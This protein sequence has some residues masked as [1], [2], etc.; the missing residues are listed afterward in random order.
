MEFLSFALKFLGIIFIIAM[1]YGLV[2]GT[3]KKDIEDYKKKIIDEYKES[4][5]FK[6]LTSKKEIIKEKIQN[7][8]NVEFFS[9]SGYTQEEIITF[10]KNKIDSNF[11]KPKKDADDTNMFYNKKVVITGNFD[12]FK[13]RNDLAKIL[14]DSGADIDMVVS[15]KT[16]YLI[17]GK[18]SGWK[19]LEKAKEFGIMIFN[20]EEILKILGINK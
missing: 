17:S 13:D 6:N 16:N 19:K 8:E 3:N 9:D 18:D 1:I 7:L 4:E 12:F 2:I 10:K 20:E 11:L 15:Q 5:E 14:Y